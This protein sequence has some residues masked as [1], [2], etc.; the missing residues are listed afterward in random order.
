MARGI[1]VLAGHT[2]EETDKQCEFL[3]FFVPLVN[4]A[5][6]KLPVQLL[7]VSHVS[8]HWTRTMGVFVG[9]LVAGGGVA[10]GT[11]VGT[12]VWVGPT[13]GVGGWQ[14]AISEVHFA[15][16]DGQQYD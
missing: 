13:V 9:A 14:A 2:Q 7:F 16:T 11:F 8:L 5:H 1:D 15:P 3:H 6:T 12:G 4:D 10:V